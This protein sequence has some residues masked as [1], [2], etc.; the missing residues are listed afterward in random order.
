MSG[1]APRQKGTRFERELVEALRSVGLDALRVPLSGAQ[2]GFNG[3]VILN[4]S[5]G[6]DKFECKVRRSGFRQVYEY[7][8]GVT[9][10]AFKQDRNEPLVAM[11]LSTFLRLLTSNSTATQASLPQQ[12]I[13][14]EVVK[15]MQQTA[16]IIRINTGKPS[17]AVLSGDG[18]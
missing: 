16:E 3:D 12:R 2:Q 8:T 6:Q 7:L 17:I 14:V 11:R 5:S 1:K 18:E 15:A 9:Y 4:T 13:P 10:L